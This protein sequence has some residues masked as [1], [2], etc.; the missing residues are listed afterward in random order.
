MDTNFWRVTRIAEGWT[1]EVEPDRIPAIKTEPSWYL[2][3]ME[4]IVRSDGGA[5]YQ[6]HV[7]S[8]NDCGEEPEV[9]IQQGNTLLERKAVKQC[10]SAMWRAIRRAGAAS[11]RHELAV[12]AE[13][14]EVIAPAKPKRK[15]KKA[16]V[17]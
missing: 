4:G 3:G 11:K 17:S 16:A 6:W 9:H 1:I 2:E 15:P 13:E 10:K 7:Y 5:G 12:P 8:A 14:L